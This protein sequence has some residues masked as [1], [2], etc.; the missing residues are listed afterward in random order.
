MISFVE[1]T[2]INNIWTQIVL[3]LDITFINL[4]TMKVHQM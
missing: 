1:Y 2:N 3:L 4:Y